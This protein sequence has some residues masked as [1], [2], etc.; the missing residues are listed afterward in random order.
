MV[1]FYTIAYIFSVVFSV[2]FKVILKDFFFVLSYI[3]ISFLFTI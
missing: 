1:F 3:N 2:Y